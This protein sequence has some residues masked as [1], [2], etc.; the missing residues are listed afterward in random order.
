LLNEMA[1]VAVAPLPEGQPVDAAMA[2]G[3]VEPAA[4]RPGP[5]RESARPSAACRM[6]ATFTFPAADTSAGGPVSSIICKGWA[7]VGSA[8][9]RMALPGTL[10]SEPSATDAPAKGVPVSMSVSCTGTVSPLETRVT[11]PFASVTPAAELTVPGVGLTMRDVDPVTEPEAALIVVVPPA[12]EVAR[13]APLIVAAAELDEDHV[14]P[15]VRICVELS[16]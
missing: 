6:T 8:T 9:I 13:P 16:L 1:L 4:L 12:M 15:L 10:G 11:R 5:S 7:P 2:V 14:T 3:E